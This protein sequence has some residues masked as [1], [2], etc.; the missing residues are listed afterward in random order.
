MIGYWHD[1]PPDQ[2]RHVLVSV[3]ARLGGYELIVEQCD[4]EPCWHWSV[5]NHRGRQIESGVAPDA[6]TAKRMAE[7]AAFHIH[8]PT[9][10]DW[11]ERLI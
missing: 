9:V 5:A 4:D 2:T 11:V 1:L 7:E 10:G 3:G 8:P 6:S